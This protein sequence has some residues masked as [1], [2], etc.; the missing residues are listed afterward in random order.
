MLFEKGFTVE[1]I[2]SQHELKTGTIQHYLLTLHQAGEIDLIP[3]IKD[4]LSTEEL[5]KGSRYFQQHENPKLSQ[6]FADLGLDYDTL[7]L[8]RLYVAKHDT[9]QEELVYAA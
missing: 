2:A 3:W 7:R 8:C 6:A 9:V 4:Q 1:Q 5:E